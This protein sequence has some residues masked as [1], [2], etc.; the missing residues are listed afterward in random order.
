MLNLTA[1]E[2]LHITQHPVGVQAVNPQIYIFIGGKSDSGK[3][4]EHAGGHCLLTWSEAVKAKLR[5]DT[6]NQQGHSARFVITEIA[7][8]QPSPGE[9]HPYFMVTEVSLCEPAI[10]PQ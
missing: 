7:Y 2:D 9:P 4:N 3:I 5:K 6:P 1:C 8:Q 10:A